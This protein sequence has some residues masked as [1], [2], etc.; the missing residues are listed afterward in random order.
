MAVPDNPAKFLSKFAG[1]RFSGGGTRRQRIDGIPEVF[2]PEVQVG[3]RR[4]TGGAD[5]PDQP[6]LGHFFPGAHPFRESG[7]MKVIGQ[8]AFGRVYKIK[9]RGKEYA[10]KS[11]DT[12]K[13]KNSYSS[14]LKE[15][16]WLLIIKH[17]NI[18]KLRFI[19]Y[20]ITDKKGI[21]SL[22]EKG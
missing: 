12:L 21:K 5:I 15:L 22:C 1:H 20:A 4:K 13:K 8:G 14:F 3:P 6:A 2:D 9:F 18:L 7:K 10:I 17:P 16:K 11:F 19:P